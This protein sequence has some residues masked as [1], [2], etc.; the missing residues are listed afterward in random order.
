MRSLLIVI[1]QFSN[2]SVSNMSPILKLYLSPWVMLSYKSSSSL[3]HLYKSRTCLFQVLFSICSHSS[4]T[5]LSLFFYLVFLALL[6]FMVGFVGFMD[7]IC[8]VGFISFISFI[9][10]I[11]SGGF[12]A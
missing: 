6:V 10:S 2:F 1:F 9:R 4:L 7:F 8:F 3:L 11:G 12:I 5:M